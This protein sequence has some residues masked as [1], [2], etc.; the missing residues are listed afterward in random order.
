MTKSKIVNTKS[1]LK[2]GI[3][4]RGA[5]LKGWSKNSPSSKQRTVML[6]QCGKKCFLGP[7]KTFP[8][9]SKN[10]C[11]INRQGIHAAYARAR[12][13]ETITKT[14]AIQ[15]KKYKNISRKAYKMLYS[16]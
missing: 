15:H 1:K 10:T 11:K 16:K 14:R 3:K 8:I 2:T 9:C 4:G 13:Y 12:E 6:K 7:D 5:Y